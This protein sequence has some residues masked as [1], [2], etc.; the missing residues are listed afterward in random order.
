MENWKKIIWTSLIF[1]IIIIIVA[2]LAPWGILSASEYLI[3]IPWYP[4]SLFYPYPTLPEGTTKGML[5]FSAEYWSHAWICILIG[6]IIA[7]IFTEFISKEKMSMWLKSSRWYSYILTSIAGAILGV[8]SCA[9]LP[10]FASL[11]R[12]GAGL[13][14]AI[15]FL[16]SGPAINPIGFLLTMNQLGLGW[17]SQE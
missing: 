10:L 4:M 5:Y 6:F 7:G 16:I 1:G 9:I 11:K 14:P 12:K 2:L 17:E 13:G 15:T 8:C 3:E